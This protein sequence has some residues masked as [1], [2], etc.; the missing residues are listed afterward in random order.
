MSVKQPQDA[1]T[2]SRENYVLVVQ[3]QPS[4]TPS[5]QHLKIKIDRGALG[6]LPLTLQHM[7]ATGSSQGPCVSTA[8]TTGKT[9]DLEV[10][11]V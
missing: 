10:I 9:K 6:T 3:G 5:P 2:N 4:G 7:P 8:L 11:N 1:T